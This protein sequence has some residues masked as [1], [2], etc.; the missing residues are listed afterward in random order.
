VAFKLQDK[1]GSGQP[2]VRVT[3]SL[4][5]IAEAHAEAVVA[6]SNKHM[7]GNVNADGWWFRDPKSGVERTN[8]DGAIRKRAG[9]DLRVE[10]LSLPAIDADGEIRL[11]EGMARVTGAYNLPTAKHVIHTLGPSGNKGNKSERALMLTYYSCLNEAQRIGA[12]SVAF[13]AISCGVLAMPLDI[14]ATAALAA[15]SDW[16]DK[17]QMATAMEGAWDEGDAAVRAVA[18]G[19]VHFVLHE[20]RPF[21]V[22]VDTA[23]RRWGP[24]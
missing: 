20:Q 16:V 2:P 22:F 21:E 6:P 18:P 8:A 12:T 9:D 1:S 14:G 11:R 5:C 15:V 10:C 19:R 4:G 3:F 23:Y 13:P 7:C 17:Q 24:P